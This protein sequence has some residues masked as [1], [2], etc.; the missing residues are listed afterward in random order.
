MY[1]LDKEIEIQI[2]DSVNNILDQY[3]EGRTL[4]TRHANKILNKADYDAYFNNK[5][6]T[7]TDARKDF[8]SNK[9]IKNL[10]EDTK[11]PGYQLF[12]NN[13]N[14]INEDLEYQSL[15]RNIL[16]KIIKDRM[17]EEND[18]KTKQVIMENIQ[19]FENFNDSEKI[20]EIKLPIM[21]LD[22]ILDEVSKVTNDTLKR[23]L[24]TFFNTYVE[25][26]DLIDKDK[27]KFRVNDMVG[28]IMNNNRISFEAAIF[29]KN[30]IIQIKKNI[31]DYSIGEFY[32]TLPA[33]VNV[34]D[35]NLKPS[36]FINK[37]ELKFTFENAITSKDVVSIISNL[38]NFT[39]EK[40]FNNFYIFSNKNNDKIK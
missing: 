34:F 29:D 17:A 20:N 10:I 31:I 33:T 32:T 13:F 25:Y 7:L 40:Q 23:V 1:N 6:R 39:F 11:Y 22:E 21:K 5:K 38:L 15:V 9:N 18:K 30:D 19:L 36:S 28:D 12:K 26:I 35:I 2:Y 24:V 16:Y 4:G 37:D 14:G 3:L 8:K 27:H